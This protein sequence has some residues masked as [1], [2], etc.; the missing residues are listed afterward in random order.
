M[1]TFCV[2][3]Y[4]STSRKTGTLLKQPRTLSLAIIPGEHIL[5]IAL[6]REQENSAP[7]KTRDQESGADSTRDQ[8]SGAD[9]TRDQESGADRDQKGG[10]D[11]RYQ[12]ETNTDREN[13]VSR[14]Q[15]TSA[16]NITNIDVSK[17]EPQPSI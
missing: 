15:E 4:E 10:T 16:N 5:S 1:L 12:Q 3:E 14:E 6:A 9:S 13:S 2:D 8:E 17:D 7:I 11:T